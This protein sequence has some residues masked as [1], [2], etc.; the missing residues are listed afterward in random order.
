LLTLDAPRNVLGRVSLR[1]GKSREQKVLWYMLL[2]VSLNFCFSVTFTL[3]VNHVFRKT[4]TFGG[5]KPAQ[6]S[7]KNYLVYREKNE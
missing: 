4:T 5:Q 7:V 1:I 3:A 2:V 6:K